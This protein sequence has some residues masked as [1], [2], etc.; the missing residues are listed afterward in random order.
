GQG[1]AVAHQPERPD[2]RG[3]APRPAAHLQRAVPSRSVAGA[4]RSQLPVRAFRQDDGR[5][6]AVS[7]D[8]TRKPRPDAGLI[9]LLLDQLASDFAAPPFREQIAAARE[10]YFGRAGKVFEDDAEVYE[11]R[12]VAC[13][14]WFVVDLSL[15]E[16][17]P[18][19]LLARERTPADAAN[20]DRRLAL[21]RIATSHRSLFDIAE[22]KGN[23]VE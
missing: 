8:E 2:R 15:S 23:R 16:G 19:V 22:V 4:Q 21:A 18:P 10:E 9:H 5:A 20:A 12:T 11:G 13:L 17:R 7:D 14:L 1:C 6:G 3:H